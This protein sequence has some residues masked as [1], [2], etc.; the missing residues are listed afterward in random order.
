M[1]SCGGEGREGRAEGR[2]R[3]DWGSGEGGEGER[4]EREGGPPFSN[5]GTQVCI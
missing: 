2:W 3:G 5:P 1:R 4:E